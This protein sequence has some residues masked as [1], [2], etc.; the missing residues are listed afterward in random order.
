MRAASPLIPGEHINAPLGDRTL[1]L[2]LPADLPQP[3]VHP[4]P[5]ALLFLSPGSTL[6]RLTRAPPLSD[7]R[8]HRIHPNGSRPPTT[9]GTP[10]NTQIRNG[11]NRYDLRHP[12]HLHLGPRAPPYRSRNNPLIP[13]L[14]PRRSRQQHGLHHHVA[15]VSSDPHL[16]PHAGTLVPAE[17]AG[18]QPTRQDHRRHQRHPQHHGPPMHVL[19]PPSGHPPDVSHPRPHPTRSPPSLYAYSHHP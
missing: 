10:H 3:G 12:I 13:P 8:R 14:S 6:H 11:G 2:P 5:R 15:T 19:P 1:L 18:Q 17:L 4:L 16:L 9:R 7:P